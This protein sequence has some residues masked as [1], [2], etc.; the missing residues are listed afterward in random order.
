M[1]EHNIVCKQNSTIQSQQQI[2]KEKNANF[3][4]ALLSWPIQEGADTPDSL[5]AQ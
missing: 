5:R 2:C 1:W 3:S 4:S